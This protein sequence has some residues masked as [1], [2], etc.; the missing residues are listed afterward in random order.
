[1]KA[2]HSLFKCVKLTRKMSGYCI[3]VLGES[4]YLLFLQFFDEILGTVQTSWYIMFLF[5]I[6]SQKFIVIE[7]KLYFAIRYNR[8]K[9]LNVANDLNTF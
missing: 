7:S 5:L 8:I 3:F 6:L 9:S 4:I 2:H 1:M